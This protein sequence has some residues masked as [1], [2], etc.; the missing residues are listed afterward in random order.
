MKLIAQNEV[1]DAYISA[2]PAVVTTLP[3]DNLQDAVR[4]RVM[5]TT[6]TAD[7]VIKLRWDDNR[8]FSAIALIRHNLSSA[9][10][11]RIQIFSDSW[12]EDEVYDSGGVI[13]N[14]PKPLGELNWGIDPLGATIF[15]GWAYAFATLYF[16]VKA[17][18]SALVTISDPLNADGYIEA[19]RLIFGYHIEPQINPAYGLKLGWTESTKQ[20][21]TEGGALR[22]E[23]KDPYRKLSFDLQWIYE[24]DRKRLFE[25]MRKIG[26][27][28]DFFI[29]IYPGAGLELERDNAM[30][31]KITGMPDFSIPFYGIHSA[32]FD[33][34]EA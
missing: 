21:R 23:S 2:E 29:S 13:A 12:W 1:D 7:Q 18:K 11:W 22:S 20:S 33:I 5:R 8:V 31:A 28:K 10:T 9:A 27:R 17:G 25:T 4:E 3:V 26:K 16:D 24:A 14:P 6:S 34:E 15:R 19:S 32:Q 30:H